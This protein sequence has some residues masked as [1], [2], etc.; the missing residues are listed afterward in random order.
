MRISPGGAIIGV[1]VGSGVASAMVI[2][3]LWAD[4]GAW[5]GSD[6]MLSIDPPLWL[7]AVTFFVLGGGAALLTGLVLVPMMRRWP[8][9]QRFPGNV[10]M[11]VASIAAAALAFVFSGELRMRG[12]TSWRCS[13]EAP[14]RSSSDWWQRVSP[15]GARRRMQRARLKRAFADQRD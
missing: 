6:Y 8:T 15:R 4:L 1:V 11:I 3:Y 9:L 10:V 12:P 2:T 5:Y 13:R 7:I 14:S